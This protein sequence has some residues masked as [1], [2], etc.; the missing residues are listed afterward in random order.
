V[1]EQQLTKLVTAGLKFKEPFDIIF[2]TSIITSIIIT[3]IITATITIIILII[4]VVVVVVFCLVVQV[5][6]YYTYKASTIPEPHP[7]AVARAKDFWHSA[8]AAATATASSA[9]TTTDGNV[10]V[11]A[12]QLAEAVAICAKSASASSA[13]PVM[14]FEGLHFLLTGFH[15][16]SHPSLATMTSLITAY[17]GKIV[18]LDE[19][20]G[21][22]VHGVHGVSQCAAA[23]NVREGV[24]VPPSSSSASSSA[25]CSLSSAQAP[26]LVL[27]A[28]SGTYRRI[29]YLLAVAMGRWVSD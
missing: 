8:H 16:R 2:V 9:G 25:G 17:H 5:R 3:I 23:P 21:I 1:N 27:V 6:W 12:R 29:K 19:A 22:G 10:V 11:R 26:R 18:G 20:A 7:S 24:A 13:S 15:Q 4:V 14:I 28:K